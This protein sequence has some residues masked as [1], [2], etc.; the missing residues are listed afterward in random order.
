MKNIYLILVII[1]FVYSCGNSPSE[2]KVGTK[3]NNQ[4]QELTI[5][6]F[7]QQLVDTFSVLR[8]YG[9]DKRSFNLKTE[10]VFQQE[11]FVIVNVTETIEYYEMQYSFALNTDMKQMP[12]NDD[13]PFYQDIY[14]ELNKL[15]VNYQLFHGHFTRTNDILEDG[16]GDFILDMKDQYESLTT[17]RTRIVFYDGKSGLKSSDFYAA[18]SYETGI[19]DPF[20]GI[21]E[22]LKISDK[23][24]Y[25]V[26][27]S[28]E[29]YIK[30]Q[31]L[32]DSLIH[33]GYDKIYK[34]EKGKWSQQP[35]V[36]TPTIV[37]S[38]AF[39]YLPNNFTFLTELDDEWVIVKNCQRGDYPGFSFF[40]DK[41]SSN[42]AVVVLA[43]REDNIDSYFL[44]GI[45]QINKHRF[46]L[47][48][49]PSESVDYGNNLQGIENGNVYFP[50]ILE[51]NDKDVSLYRVTFFG[52]KKYLTPNPDKYNKKDC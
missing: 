45:S 37:K 24:P 41:K 43:E 19:C 5:D 32:C 6:S 46:I 12:S 16:S 4:E 2:N 14:P 33:L 23:K 9:K 11:D 44:A 50:M 27:I 29:E 10:I 26:T 13:R 35:M 40:I 52:S 38:K 8:S 49:R 20:V 51:Q 42:E 48:W 18:S 25:S 17:T 15:K 31:D 1:L 47:Y 34:Q 39:K 7:S 21:K 30:N 28:R 36:A 3:E 22:T